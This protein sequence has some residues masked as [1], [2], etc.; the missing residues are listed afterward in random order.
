MTKKRKSS[1]HKMKKA[2]VV[3]KIITITITIAQLI[4]QR[5]ELFK[6][7]HY[8]FWTVGSCTS[9]LKSCGVTMGELF[10]FGL[11]LHKR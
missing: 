3:G 7:Q 4:L 11:L 2:K 9:G 10:N 8:G 6:K 1:Q 5:T